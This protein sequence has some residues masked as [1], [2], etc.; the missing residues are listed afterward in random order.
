MAV[1][2]APN[3]DVNVIVAVEPGVY[4]FVT[5]ILYAAF[6]VAAYEIAEAIH[7][8]P[9]NSVVIM[10]RAPVFEAAEILYEISIFELGD[11]G[12]KFVVHIK[13]PSLD[14]GVVLSRGTVDGPEDAGI[15]PVTT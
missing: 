5:A 12:V 2:L 13:L 15:V 14:K 9:A 7:V 8:V 4:T 10:D 6:D 11:K 1:V 3:L